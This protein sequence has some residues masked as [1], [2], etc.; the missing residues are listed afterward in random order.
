MAAPA[1][2]QEAANPFGRVYPP[3]VYTTVRLQGQPPR[4]DGRLDDPAWQQGE[5]SGDF[6]QQI[7]TEGAKPSQPTELKI[8]YDEK[9]VYFAIRAYDEPAKIHR[10]PGRRDD[11]VGDIVGICFDSDND[12][13]SGFEFDLTAGGSKIDLILGNGESE[14]DTNWNAVWHGATGLEADAWTAEFQIPL[15]Q[16]RYGSQDE[17]VWGIHAWRWID[18]NQEEVQWQLIPRRNTGRMHQLGELHGIR[19]LRPYRRIELLPH[20]LGRAAN[21]PA[22]DRAS[23]GSGSMGLDAKVGL[24]T[25]FTLDATVNPDFGQVEADPSVMNLTAYETFFDEKRPFFLEGRSILSFGIEDSDALFYSRR[26]G[27]APSYFPALAPGETTR[28]PESTTILGAVK[29]TGKTASGLSIGII[30]SVTQRETTR[31]EAPS[32][33][34]EQTVEPWGSYSV[35]RV[36]QDWD[37]GNTSLGAM[38]TFTERGI[39]EPA[40]SFL[41][42][43]AFS[44]GFDFVRYFSNRSWVVE[45]SGLASRVS[46]DPRAIQAL[47]TNAVHYYQRP[48]ASHLGLEPQA[49][50]LSGHGGSLRFARTDKGRFRL[51]SH[52]HWYS[53]GLELNDLGFLR[54]ADLLANQLFVGW[55]ETTPRGPFR[56]YSAQLSR[57]DSWDFGGLKTWGSTE[58]DL[59][60]QFKNKWNANVGLRWI[61]GPVDTRVLR[62]GP[63][64]RQDSFLC[65]NAGFESDSSRRLG[66]S[67]SAHGHFHS[68]QLSRQ[69]DLSA[70]AWVRPTRAM[71]LSANVS[72]SGNRDDLQYVSSETLASGSRFVLGRIAQRTWALTF[73]ASLSLTPDLTLQYYG[74]PFVS[75]GR[76]SDFKSATDTL[77]PGYASRFHAFSPGE[78]AYQAAGNAYD[79]S[80]PA[81]PGYSFGNPDFSFRQFRSN[82]VLRW[83]YRPGSSLY[84]VWSQGRT[85]AS[86]R[87]QGPLGGNWDSLWATAPQNVFLIKLSYWFAP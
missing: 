52:F 34:R 65:T 43:R 33:S 2:A 25:N 86:D 76:Y 14:W 23:D 32:G 72:Y 79:V 15:S 27:H 84:A 87:W 49:T 31:I 3:R 63:A 37:K 58:L 40:L 82:L 80:E 73:R 6:R 22:A 45:A 77:A 35:A 19:G 57:N 11:F 26:I 71:R 10:W 44:G 70:S 38:L 66:G 53:P 36:H 50:T 68:E 85:S 24:S 61:E 78:L 20:L 54:Q 67:A 56:S 7:P 81:G 75:T 28:L 13:R 55:S 39:D 69:S 42:K 21:D 4:V 48:D 46:G 29:V 60:G 12:K 16:L 8:L 41:P 64:L 62:G 74:S 5:W 18:R 47:Q 30:Q 51:S 1:V 9:N 59:S 83:E 17:Q